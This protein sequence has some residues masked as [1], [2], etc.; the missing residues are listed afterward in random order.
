MIRNQALHPVGDE[1]YYFFLA[2][3]HGYLAALP[4]PAV[5][6]TAARPAL[7]ETAGGHLSPRELQGRY[8]VALQTIGG[9]DVAERKKPIYQRNAQM[10]EQQAIEEAAQALRALWKLKK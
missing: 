6:D 7:M 2:E 4:Q 3:L 5:L 1:N 8:S 9:E 10:T